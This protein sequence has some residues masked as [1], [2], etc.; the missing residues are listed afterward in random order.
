[1]RVF[2][3]N[4][5]EKNDISH[6]APIYISVAPER[7]ISFLHRPLVLKVIY[8]HGQFK[9][10]L[11]LVEAQ[12]ELRLAFSRVSNARD[13]N[14]GNRHESFA[15]IITNCPCAWIVRNELFP[16]TRQSPAHFCLSICHSPFACPSFFF[17]NRVL[18]TE[19]KDRG[20]PSRRNWKTTGDKRRTITCNVFCNLAMSIRAKSARSFSRL[21]KLLCGNKSGAFLV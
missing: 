7:E 21:K 20:T 18:L 13:C 14:L 16:D 8:H 5:D 3:G 9:F 17:S 2:R 6:F 4:A 11:R 12:A 15:H 1:M 19:T 10:Q